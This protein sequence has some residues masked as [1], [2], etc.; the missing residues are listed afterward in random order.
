MNTILI[1]ANILTL[2]TFIIHTFG[3]DKELRDIQPDSDSE[4]WKSKQVKW[5]MA[6][7]AFHIV[8]A[9]FL[10]ATAGLTLINF[11]DFFEDKILILRI[12]AVYFFAYGIAFLMSL[13]ISKK[14][15]NIYIKLWQWVLMF[16]ISGLIYLGTK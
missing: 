15:K 4:N 6:R 14:F 7:G 13:I 11:T 1:A 5:S 2:L 12:L 9:D 8:S 16:I 10:L 3:G